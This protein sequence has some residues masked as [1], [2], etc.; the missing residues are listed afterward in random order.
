MMNEM[1]KIIESRFSCRG[2]TDKKLTSDEVNAIANAAVQSPSANNSQR[3]QIIMVTNKELIQEMDDEALKVMS[4]F[5]DK[6]MY[7]RMMSRGGS[8]FYNA[9]C[10]AYIAT[11]S[12]DVALDCGIVSENIALAA[13]ALGLGNCICGLAGL[14]FSEDKGAYFKEKLGFQK[15]FGFGMAVLIGHA[16]EPGKPHDPDTSKITI[17]D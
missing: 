3:W 16:K 10:V 15:D 6:S 13:T 5:E 1:L 8:V 7:E 9:S 17:I 14:S 11:S 4:G 12:A 2:Y